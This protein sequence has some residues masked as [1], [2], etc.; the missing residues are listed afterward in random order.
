MS[1]TKSDE[2]EF[3]T[4]LY[5]LVDTSLFPE[6]SVESTVNMEEASAEA[7]ILSILKNNRTLT[8]RLKNLLKILSRIAN[9][10][11]PLLDEPLP[12]S[13]NGPSGPATLGG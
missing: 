11:E 10:V 5:K 4:A 13:R 1:D 9:Q 7:K 12:S 8:P 6:A 2:K 3:Q